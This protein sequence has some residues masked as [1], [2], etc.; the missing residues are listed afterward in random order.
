MIKPTDECSDVDI[1]RLFRVEIWWKRT[2]RSRHDP[3]DYSRRKNS[4]AL[5]NQMLVKD[6]CCYV[7]VWNIQVFQKLESSDKI[8]PANTYQ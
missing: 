4:D 2:C 3:S 1:L 6:S 8:L 7:W 5:E